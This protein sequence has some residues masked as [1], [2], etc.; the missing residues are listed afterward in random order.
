MD[1][2]CSL[3]TLREV[4]TKAELEVLDLNATVVRFMS[5]QVARLLI[6]NPSCDRG[7]SILCETLGPGS[8]HQTSSVPNICQIAGTEVTSTEVNGET[9]GYVTRLYYE[10]I[11]VTMTLIIF[12]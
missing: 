4:N 1:T 5:L 2:W 6:I 12:E 10:F 3:P 11:L 7:G 8:T 9:V